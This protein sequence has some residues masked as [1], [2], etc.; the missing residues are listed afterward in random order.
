MRKA[1]PTWIWPTSYKPSP[2]G[3]QRLGRVLHW[4]LSIVAG[5]I[6]ALGVLQLLM[7]SQHLLFAIAS[8]I[9]GRPW[10]PLGLADIRPEYETYGLS[11][12]Q[13]IHFMRQE[14]YW[15]FT[16]ALIIALK[17]QCLSF[18]VFIFGRTS[19]YVFSGE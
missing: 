6:A 15:E 11:D 14:G 12:K 2:N 17:F 3:F 10:S 1:L 16:A 19:R 18:A 4:T 7:G 5:V 8:E 13:I 9:M